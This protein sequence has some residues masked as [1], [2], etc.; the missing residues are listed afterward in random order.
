MNRVGRITELLPDG[1]AR[2]ALGKTEAC[3]LCPGA[4]G[5][6]VKKDAELTALNTVEAAIGSNVVVRSKGLF[7]AEITG[8]L[9]NSENGFGL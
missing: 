7:K 2:V 9:H 6:L 3:E 1:K 8:I 5:C 4:S